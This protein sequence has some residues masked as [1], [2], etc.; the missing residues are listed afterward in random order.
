MINFL[1]KKIV[2]QY[3]CHTGMILKKCFGAFFG[4]FFVG[5]IFERNLIIGQNV[6]LMEFCAFLE[7]PFF[8]IGFGW[9][10][11]D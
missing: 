6:L 11:V 4:H 3:F 10:N 7:F 2:F 5:E 1:L 9:K 8:N